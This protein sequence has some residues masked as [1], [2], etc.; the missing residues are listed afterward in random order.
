MSHYKCRFIS[1]PALIV[2]I[3]AVATKTPTEKKERKQKQEFRNEL[4]YIGFTS[5]IREDRDSGYIYIDMNLPIN[6]DEAKNFVDS[7]NTMYRKHHLNPV[8]QNNILIHSLEF[9]FSVLFPDS[10]PSAYIPPR[11]IA[12]T[13]QDFLSSGDHDTYD[14]YVYSKIAAQSS[15]RYRKIISRRQKGVKKPV[16]PQIKEGND[17]SLQCKFGQNSCP[18]FSPVQDN[19]LPGITLEQ[20]QQLNKESA[21]QQNQEYISKMRTIIEN[22]VIEAT[23]KLFKFLQ[24]HCGPVDY[25]EKLKMYYVTMPGDNYITW[26]KLK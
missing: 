17:K 9:L 25:S 4:L 7:Y 15:P 18:Q 8:A 14:E 12:I 10:N 5:S 23:P 1:V 6:I 22:C 13:P 11:D 2:K 24:Q 21:S 26:V 16:G 20:Q 19:I 3:I